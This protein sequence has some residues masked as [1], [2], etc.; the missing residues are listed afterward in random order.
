MYRR[1]M[2][3]GGLFKQRGMFRREGWKQKTFG[4]WKQRRE[5]PASQRNLSGETLG[6]FFEFEKEQREQR[7]GQQ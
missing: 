4:Q 7:K 3:A 5:R 2:R 1:V 6:M